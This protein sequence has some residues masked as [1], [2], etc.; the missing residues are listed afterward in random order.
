MAVFDRSFASQSL[1]NGRSYDVLRDMNKNL[2]LPKGVVNMGAFLIGHM[3]IKDTDKWAQY[4][5]Q[6]PDTLGPWGAKLIFRGQRSRVLAG[7]HHHTDTV[8]IQ[9]PSQDALNGWYTSNA[10]QA[11]IPLRSEAAEMVLVSYDE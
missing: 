9:F 1:K 6:V 11:L 5:K 2:K 7:E 3:T 8:V 10:Y 4:R